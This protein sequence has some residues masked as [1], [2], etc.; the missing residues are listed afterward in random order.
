MIDLHIH[1]TFSD[2]SETPAELVEL[3]LAAGVRAL[4]LTDHD[5]V[6]GVPAFFAAC[7]QRRLAG[8][9]GVEISAEVPRGTLHILG[10]GIDP[11][12]RELNEKL[13]LV[14]DGRDWR[15]RQILQKLNA[16]GLALEWD[17]VAAQAGED[18][19]GRPH[20]AQAMIR[21]G[22]VAGTQE[23]F[24]RYLAKGHPAYVDRF[25]LSPEEGIRLIRAAGGVAVMAHPFTWEPDAAALEGKL[26]ALREAGLG[27]IEAHYSDHSPEQTIAC[28]RLARRLGLAVSGGS[29]YHGGGKDGISLGTGRGNLTVPDRLFDPLVAL[30]TTQAGIA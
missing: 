12:H 19:V 4:A 2:G 29:D 7:R 18:V 9:S 5:N 27:G 26:A 1:S 17:E 24:D 11:A 6:Q 15:N 3:A 16:L 13:G 10:L 28:L 23:A 21:R 20:F 30:V 14:L 8:L 22:Y 25:R